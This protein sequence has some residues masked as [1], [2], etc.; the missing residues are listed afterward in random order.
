MVNVAEIMDYEV[1]MLPD[2]KVV[3]MMQRMINDGSAWRLQ[4]SY[5]RE[6]MSLIESGDC[7]LGKTG[8]HGYYGNYVPSRF[9]VKSGTKGS[10]AYAR[11]MRGSRTGAG[12]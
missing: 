12:M 6:A 8:H 5:G 4:G 10:I 11:R 9:E 1:G 2:E 7:I 3:K